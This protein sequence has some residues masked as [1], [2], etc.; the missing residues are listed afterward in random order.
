MLL[1]HGSNGQ[2]G[3]HFMESLAKE[4]SVRKPSGSGYPVP[5][6]D[7]PIKKYKQSFVGMFIHKIKAF[8]MV[9][10][11]VPSCTHVFLSQKRAENCLG[12]SK[13]P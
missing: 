7:M 5:L 12:A 10:T 9:L 3:Q 8:G 4:T 11:P 13:E 2:Q 6:A 1:G